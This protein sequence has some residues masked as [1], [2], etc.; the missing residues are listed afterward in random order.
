MIEQ[1]HTI[2]T[3]I[4]GLPFVSLIV[5]SI[6]CW[7]ASKKLRLFIFETAKARGWHYDKEDT[8][9]IPFYPFLI[10]VLERLFFT[11]LVAFGGTAVAPAIV[12]WMIVKMTTGWNR[13]TKTGTFYRM[14]AFTG[15]MVSLISMLFAVLGG[16]VANGSIPLFRLWE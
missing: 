9:I 1:H 15:L 5:G 8:E 11:L 10:G 13:I 3:W 6:V 7:L 16:L 2:F 14:L 12:L 4:V